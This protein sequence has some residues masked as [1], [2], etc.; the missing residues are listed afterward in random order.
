MSYVDSVLRFG[1]L[2]L[3]KTRL[4]NLGILIVY[5]RNCFNPFTW[6]LS[7]KLVEIEDLLYKGHSNAT[8][9]SLEH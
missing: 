2:F 4:F 1:L 3:L 6:K 9:C 5:T 7:T 8:R